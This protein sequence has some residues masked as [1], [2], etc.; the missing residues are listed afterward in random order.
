MTAKST[1]DGV[2]MVY[3]DGKWEVDFPV[4]IKGAFLWWVILAVVSAGLAFIHTWVAASVMMAGTGLI[5]WNAWR[6]IKKYKLPTL[7]S[8]K[9]Y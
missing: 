6:L 4:F 9:R 1:V 5:G 3:K 7:P 2:P 8:T